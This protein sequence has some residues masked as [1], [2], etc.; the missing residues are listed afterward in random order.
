[1]TL[2]CIV[3]SC[4][5]SVR[6]RQTRDQILTGGKRSMSAGRPMSS[7]VSRPNSAHN[8]RPGSARNIGGTKHQYG[9]QFEVF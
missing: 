9:T 2:S 8:S 4:S 6:D 1:M 5:F 3:Y 7:R